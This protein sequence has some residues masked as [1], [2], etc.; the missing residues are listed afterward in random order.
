M[1]EEETTCEEVTITRYHSII[2]VITIIIIILIMII[3]IIIII[4][5]IMMMTRCVDNEVEECIEIPTQI[6]IETK[7]DV[8]ATECATRVNEV[9]SS[10]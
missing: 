1:P 4:L 8:E 7:S 9:S 2:I 5:I 3:V 10:S 6:T